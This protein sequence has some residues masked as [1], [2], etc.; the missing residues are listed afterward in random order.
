M[1]FSDKKF[2]IAAG[3]LVIVMVAALGYV[4]KT[5]VQTAIANSD[6]TFEMPRPK[7]FFASLFDLN[8]REVSRTYVN[9]FDKKKKEEAKKPEVVKA[10]PAPKPAAAVAKKAAPKK[11][12]ATKK[13]T[14]EVNVVQDSPHEGVGADGIRPNNKSGKE[15]TNGAAGDTA[16]ADPTDA[17]KNSADQWRALLNAQPT[18]ENV[19]KMVAALTAGELDSASFYSIVGDL[20]KN[21]KADTQKMGVYALSAS[22]YKAPAFVLASEY[23]E[24]LAPEAQTAA[25][26]YLVSYATKGYLTILQGALQSSKAS[27]VEVA[28]QVVIEGYQAAK[29]GNASTPPRASRGDEVTSSVSGY[30]KFVPIFQSLARSG[31]ATIAQLANSAL[32]QIQTSV[33]S[34]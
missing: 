33:A 28:A 19:D 17:I 34:L 5:P 32:S 9:P 12:D 26:A 10:L 8:G 20:L 6:F 1:G 14:V 4:L 25:H 30:S 22:G 18:K 3:A 15:G 7:A 31:D 29:S 11:D 23:Y 16:A 13:P 27:V 2:E 21:N 24:Q